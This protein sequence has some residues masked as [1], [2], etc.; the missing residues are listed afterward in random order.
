VQEL[1]VDAAPMVSNSTPWQWAIRLMFFFRNHLGETT[2]RHRF[3]ARQSFSSHFSGL[4]TVEVALQ[5]I[6]AACLRVLGFDPK[7]EIAFCCDSGTS[8]QRALKA[9]MQGR[10]C[11]MANVLDHVPALIPF[12]S[13]RAPNYSEMLQVALASPTTASGRCVAHGGQ[14]CKWQRADGNVSGSPCNSW[15][16]EGGMAKHNSPWVACTL[17][18]ARAVK[19][20]DLPFAI[21]ENLR[22]FDAKILADVLGNEWLIVVIPVQAVDSGFKFIKRDRQYAICIRRSR[23]RVAMDLKDFYAA[24]CLELKQ[25]PSITLAALAQATDL[26]L[27]AEENAVRSFRGMSGIDEAA[28]PSRNWTY[29]LRP[30]QLRLLQ[31]LEAAWQRKY[32]QNAQRDLQCVFVLSRSEKWGCKHDLD[33]PARGVLPTLTSKSKR[34][35]WLPARNRWL[36]QRELAAAMGYPVYPELAQAAL[37]PEDQVTA[38]PGAPGLS[39]M[40]GRAMHVGSVGMMLV[41]GTSRFSWCRSCSVE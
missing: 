37:V 7:W 38:Q 15:S 29:L 30:G 25:A 20:S 8:Q 4:G 12:A 11:V 2:L 33:A 10:C 3:A 6:R 39:E 35:I 32:R 9:R 13:A 41:W 14:Q 18:W 5:H 21:H 1:A 16:R 22:G 36:L 26:E 17:A 28:G 24:A 31:K 40:L 27:L 23:L 34:C 19:D